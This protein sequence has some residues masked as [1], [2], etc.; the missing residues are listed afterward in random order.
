MLSAD[1]RVETFD[2]I[3]STNTWLA[4]RA[5]AGESEGLVARTDFQTAGRGRLGRVWEA[6]PGSSLLFSVLLRPALAD[7]QRQIAVAAVALAVRAAIG[8]ATGQ[9]PDVKW[10]NDLLFGPDKVAGILAE[11]VVTEAGVAIVVGVGVN[12]STVDPELRN[13]TTLLAATGSAPSP[14]FLLDLILAALSQRRPLL[15][16]P[17]GCATL[18][19][20]YEQALVTL[21]Q[22]VQIT[23]P[24]ALLR[25]RACGLGA[26]GELIVDVAG[27]LQ[28]F[29]VGD[30]IHV[31]PGEYA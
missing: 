14:A 27:E 22:Q 25:G 9:T 18:L 19:A 10:P 20:E 23:T 11:A 31:R 26:A 7:G 16:H 3:D 30:V 2:S 15:E 13:A 5:R 24:T 17:A 4:D 28:R 6:P 1:W 12:C 29:S 8:E 21:G